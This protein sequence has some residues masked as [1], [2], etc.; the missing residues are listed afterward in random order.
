MTRQNEIQITAVLYL[1]FS[2]LPRRIDCVDVS[3]KG[4]RVRDRSPTENCTVASRYYL[5]PKVQTFVECC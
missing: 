4:L 5:A 1:H 2:L 3:I